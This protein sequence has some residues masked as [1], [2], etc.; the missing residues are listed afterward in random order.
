[1][2]L[3]TE[4]HRFVTCSDYVADGN[5]AS[6][7]AFSAGSD[8]GDLLMPMSSNNVY[9]VTSITTGLITASKYV[10]A[11]VASLDSDGAAGNYTR[12]V[13]CMWLKTGNA[14]TG[15]QAMHI[16]LEPPVR[17][18]YSSNSHFLTLRLQTTD[19]DTVANAMY[20][21]FTTPA[22]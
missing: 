18:Q 9:H 10:R 3:F 7:V 19:S 17:V 12:H 15:A 1:M 13:P 20:S 16:P 5:G 6:S 22:A 4:F 11:A 8:M 21:G 2:S 14:P